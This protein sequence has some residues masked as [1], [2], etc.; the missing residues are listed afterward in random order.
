MGL[1]E[2]IMGIF[3]PKVKPQKTQEEIDAANFQAKFY[4][5]AY[6]GSGSTTHS[7]TSGNPVRLIEGTAK[8]S[9]PAPSAPPASSAT[10]SPAATAATAATKLLLTKS[11]PKQYAKVISD[12]AKKYGVDPL[13]LSALLRQESQFDPTAVSP[14]GA[15]GI[16]QFTPI[17]RRE[18][19]NQ[20]FG[21]FDPNNPEQAIPAAA[22]FLNFLGGQL[23]KQ[24]P[25]EER[26]LRAVA[27]YNAGP[28]TIKAAI[29][30][31]HNMGIQKPTMKDLIDN[32][33]LPT[34]TAGYVPKIQG[35]TQETAPF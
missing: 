23:D 14:A 7:D 3:N 12:A 26:L 20:G 18:L 10:P 8:A 27:A 34:E 16:A 33:L 29:S 25:P 4:P 2:R 11:T 31:A 15:K 17:A 1:L 22:F 28:G 13:V 6:K 21:R 35:Y 24:G 32:D 30:K 5:N 9:T 19:E